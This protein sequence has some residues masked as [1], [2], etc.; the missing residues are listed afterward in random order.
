MCTFNSLWKINET[1]YISG[2]YIT[3][4]KYYW[5]RKRSLHG[6]LWGNVNLD[7]REHLLGLEPL[8]LLVL[9]MQKFHMNCFP[10]LMF[11]PHDDSACSGGDY[12]QV[13]LKELPSPKARVVD[14]NKRL[15]TPFISGL[16]PKYLLPADLAGRVIVVGASQRSQL[17][18]VKL[19]N[20]YLLSNLRW[21][22]LW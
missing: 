10:S 15:Q 9:P 18:I 3:F 12:D 2:I 20:T 11:P 5:E 21:W 17:Y 8:V 13:R 4:Y 22:Y 6:M 16:R 19:F 1:Q 7:A 14:V